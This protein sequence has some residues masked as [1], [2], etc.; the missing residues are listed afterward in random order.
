[1]QIEDVALVRIEQIFPF[2]EKTV[3]A[4]LAPY[5]KADVVWCQEEPENMG[6][7][8]FVDRRIE[9]V[10][11]SSDIKAKRPSYAGRPAAASPA[12]GL[13]KAHAEQQA[14]LVSEALGTR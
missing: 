13:A 6:A 11:E 3:R 12:T 9:R 10:L 7:W 5:K 2:P 14:M 1:K 4:V 8:R